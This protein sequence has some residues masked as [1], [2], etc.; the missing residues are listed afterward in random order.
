MAERAL[1][2]LKRVAD[3]FRPGGALSDV[4]LDTLVAQTK[5]PVVAPGGAVP[6]M[7]QEVADTWER[8]L[9]EIAEPM[10]L[11]TREVDS[12]EAEYAAMRRSF[13][14]MEAV[15]VLVLVCVGLGA[16][17]FLHDKMRV[18]AAA[19]ATE[20]ILLTI[21]AVL[22]ACVLMRVV[23]AAL[24]ASHAKTRKVLSDDAPLLRALV[25][26]RDH[27]ARLLLVKYAYVRTRG[28]L[29]EL[30][31][32]QADVTD[33]TY[34][35]TG[36]Y[37]CAYKELPGKE[38]KECVLATIDA[39][40][41]L[42]NPP[43]ISR[44]VR[45]DDSSSSQTP[46]RPPYCREVLVQLADNLKGIRDDAH[47]WDRQ[48][49]WRCVSTG[50]E[51]ARALV[52]PQPLRG[53][54]A[55]PATEAAARRAVT[56]DVAPLLRLDVRETGVV[57]EAGKPSGWGTPWLT[58][59]GAPAG[60]E[61]VPAASKGACWR[62]AQ[63][64]GDV[65]AAAFV[66]GA[67]YHARGATAPMPAPTPRAGVEDTA[68]V[69]VDPAGGAALL[70]RDAPAVTNAPTGGAVVR[71]S[72]ASTQP[73]ASIQAALEKAGYNVEVVGGGKG[74][75]G[76]GNGGDVA[77][78]VDQT[79][80]EWSRA[81]LPSAKDT[82]AKDTTAEEPDPT[83]PPTLTQAVF[84]AAGAAGATG[85]RTQTVARVAAADLA[86]HLARLG[87][88]AAALRTMAAPLAE[89]IAPLGAQAGLDLRAGREH[90]A[91]VH[92]AVREHY[93]G[94]AAYEAS[95]VR[96]AVDDVLTAA[97]RAMARQARAQATG[98]SAATREVVAQRLR[99]MTSAQLEALHKRAAS[100]A[101][102]VRDYGQRFERIGDVTP[103]DPLLSS[104]A[105]YIVTLMLIAYTVINVQHTYAGSETKQG[106]AVRLIAGGSV[107][108]LVV[109]L[110]AS[111]GARARIAAH[112]NS[113][114]LKA[115]TYALQN[116]AAELAHA[117]REAHRRL[118]GGG[119]SEPADAA[120]MTLEAALERARL[121]AIAVT[122]AYDSCNLVMRDQPRLPFP[123]SQVVVH[124]LIAICVL[125][126]LVYTFDVLKPKD[127]VD[128]MRDLLGVRA[129]IRR[130]DLPMPSDAMKLLKRSADSNTS[131]REWAVLAVAVLFAVFALWVPT[132]IPAQLVADEKAIG[133]SL[134]C[135]AA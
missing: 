129:M 69:R 28:N 57:E 132:T 62:L 133:M 94:G 51:R 3:A 27:S 47:A 108:L 118:H 103:S 39:C 110:V 52:R 122:Q 87:S 4:D 63:S 64:D 86:T 14:F 65:R 111:S 78:W 115:N 89:A 130:G 5:P 72:A 15:R 33:Y 12:L 125:A 81:M 134:D 46:H 73:P 106:A 55:G 113:S 31:L 20:T 45:G 104:L 40:T 1:L 50:V 127:T 126:V 61:R 79:G 131:H 59:G 23:A 98:A 76:G 70:V 38:A 7:A 74:G 75:G 124:G 117:L 119:A 13:G 53:P 10:H 32:H 19:G 35:L 25:K 11:L 100:V 29:A 24:K 71:L 112:H 60:F 114:R 26:V 2:H 41:D 58:R 93:G 36:R 105:P 66:G 6:L 48:A 37:D 42:Q 99:A 9:V 83:L 123:T 95:G 49:L 80:Q 121:A 17:Y 107:V 30:E 44:V 8:V 56:D 34:E 18:G 16:G 116:G 22:A 88:A 54:P 67:C 102:C 97:A 68:M 101:T 84:G 43:S 128:L 135:T 96:A 90:R 120:A 82:T 21:T 77:W 92:Q 85:V 109:S 91:L